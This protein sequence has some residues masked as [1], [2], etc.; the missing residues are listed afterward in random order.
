M[1][2]VYSELCRYRNSLL[3]F[4]KRL[5]RR[6]FPSR[7]Y[8]EFKIE[9]KKYQNRLQKPKIKKEKKNPKTMK[10]KNRSEENEKINLGLRICLGLH[11]SMRWG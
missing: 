1:C 2:N 5:P 9:N 7:M 8:T 10:K 11:A 6:S 4:S 3:P